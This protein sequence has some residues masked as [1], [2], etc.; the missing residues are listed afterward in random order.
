MC[1]FNFVPAY[2]VDEMTPEVEPRRSGRHR[3][4]ISKLIFSCIYQRLMPC[5]QY[6]H[7]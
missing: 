2:I 7:G 4:W 3:H 5:M 1:I 6:C